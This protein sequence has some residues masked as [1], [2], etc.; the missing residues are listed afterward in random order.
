MI[1]VSNS[2][3]VRSVREAVFFPFDSFNTPFLGGLSIDLVTP[4]K[5]HTPVVRKGE[6]GSADSVQVGYYGSVIELDGE[7]RMW[8]LGGGSRDAP[9]IKNFPGW[10]MEH[11]C[12]ATSR[13]GIT[14]SKP[15]LGLVEY[16]GS[17]HNNLVDLAGIRERVDA[18]VVIH[19]PQEPDPNRRFKMVFESRK[20]GNQMGVAFSSDGLHWE[21]SSCNPVLPYIIEMSGLI[22][23]GNCYYANGQ[24]GGPGARIL[25]TVAS[26]DFEHWTSA[27]NFGHRRDNIPDRLPR[28]SGNMGPQVHLGASLWDRGNT[29][30]GF[31]GI[32]NGVTQD[33]RSVVMNLG[34]LVT[35]DAVH[36]HEPIPDFP[37]VPAE[38][39]A[40]GAR[41]ALMQGQGWGGTESET[42]YWYGAWR[43]G[44]VRLARWERDRLGYAHVQESWKVDPPHLWTAPFRVQDEPAEVYLNVDGLSEHSS[45]LVEVTDEEFK[46]LPGFEATNC[47]RVPNGLRVSVSWQERSRIPISDKAVRLRLSFLGARSLDVKLYAVYVSDSR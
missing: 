46:P 21:E 19:E 37:I 9:W 45:I 30:L 13:D 32:W 22:H 27:C 16:G 5:H 36:Y 44:E 28:A 29:I 20:Y 39:E 18:I 1:S 24:A 8:Y 26:Y 34:L 17:R 25:C 42:L 41:S 7:Y 43:E 12:Y 15:D 10:H 3:P 31:Y 14:W 47:R 4:K 33:R 2:G 11:V 38:E 35:T 40:D 23:L 6:D